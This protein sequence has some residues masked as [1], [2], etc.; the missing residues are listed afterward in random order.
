[1]TEIGAWMLIKFKENLRL[2]VV[3]LMK[4]RASEPQTKN[5]LIKTHSKEVLE[6]YPDFQRVPEFLTSKKYLSNK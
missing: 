5:T 6:I 3:V 2:V 1:M 4:K